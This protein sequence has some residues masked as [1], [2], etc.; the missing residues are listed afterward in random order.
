M[1]LCLRYLYI[2]L[3]A[4]GVVQKEFTSLCVFMTTSLLVI[5]N[6]EDLE[7]SNSITDL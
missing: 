3:K 6:S 7:P 4:C 2:D 1:V 5:I